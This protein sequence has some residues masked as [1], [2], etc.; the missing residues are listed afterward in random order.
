MRNQFHYN[1]QPS[2]SNILILFGLKINGNN[3]S[4]LASSKCIINGF[5]AWDLVFLYF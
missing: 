3:I 1:K 2:K 5:I 4:L